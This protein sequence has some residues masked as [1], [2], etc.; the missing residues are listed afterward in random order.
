M[1]TTDLPETSVPISTPSVQP[2]LQGRVLPQYSFRTV[3]IGMTLLALAAFIYRQASLGA[4]WAG[5][6]VAAAAFLLG[7][8]ALYALLFLLAWIPALIG[9]DQW[10]DVGKGNPFADGQLPPQLLPPSEPKP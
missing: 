6:F 4:V 7:C 10:E 3:V 2:R 9:K 1:S 8:F 5:A